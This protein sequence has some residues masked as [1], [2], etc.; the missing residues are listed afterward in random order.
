[1]NYDDK[2]LCWMCWLAF[3]G[4]LLAGLPI[5]L[6]IGGNHGKADDTSTNRIIAVDAGKTIDP[7]GGNSVRTFRVTA[8]CPCE[9]CC[10]RWSRIPVESGK[11]RT[12]GGHTIR[13]GDRFCAAPAS[14]RYGQWFDIPGYGKVPCLDRGQAITEKGTRRIRDRKTTITEHDR[15]DVYFDTHEEAL[16]WGIQY[17]DVTL[18]QEN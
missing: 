6:L 16:E 12:A 17:L 4:V 2:K 14:Y 9:K 11:R 13:P 3:C 5:K 10:G 7:F 8:Y 15:L 18:S 1:M